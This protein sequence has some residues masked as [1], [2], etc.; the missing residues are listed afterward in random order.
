M[1]GFQLR[2][3]DAGLSQG[4]PPP[5]APWT[6][7]RAALGP[8]P[9]RS[10]PGARHACAPDP[11][12]GGPEPDGAPVSRGSLP[13][14][15]LRPELPQEPVQPS[16][17]VFQR[18]LAGMAGRRQGNRTVAELERLPQALKPGPP[19]HQ[20]TDLPRETILARGG[21]QQMVQDLF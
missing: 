16:P 20:T 10:A 21:R 2:D 17:A 3:H 14:A 19:R 11:R 13:S 4:I 12:V 7:A 18:P 9:S 8:S 6:G 5:P 15:P 1:E